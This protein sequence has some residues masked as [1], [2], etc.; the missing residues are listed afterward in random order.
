MSAL[1]PTAVASATTPTFPGTD[2]RMPRMDLERPF[3]NRFPPARDPRFENRERSNVAKWT[4]AAITAGSAGKQ[5]LDGYRIL[6]KYREAVPA[7]QA[8]K[9]F[10]NLWDSAQGRAYLN[11]FA[12]QAPDTRSINPEP[13]PGQTFTGR[14]GKLLRL[15]T[16]VGLGLALLQFPTAVANVKDG[17]KEGPS[18]LATTQSGRTGVTMTVA[19]L[20]SAGSLASG[21]N[22]ARSQAL[23]DAQAGVARGSLG[24]EAKAFAGRTLAAPIWGNRWL[25]RPAMIAGGLTTLNE[26]GRF[27]TRDKRE[28]TLEVG[29]GVTTAYL[30]NS[31]VGHIRG[32]LGKRGLRTVTAATLRDPFSARSFIRP[33]FAKAGLPLLAVYAA[34]K[35]GAFD[36]MDDKDERPPAPPAAPAPRTP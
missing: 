15:S 8:G 16:G 30:L 9:R 18:G 13:R 22:W 3:S 24:H 35:L 12:L 11:Q 27:A 2:L 21:V 4:G 6:P 31:T 5:A 36:W 25:L 33:S 32:D 10:H 19:S 26:T 17:L 28:R 14:D 34:N 29:G 1:G 20:L 23:K 7:D